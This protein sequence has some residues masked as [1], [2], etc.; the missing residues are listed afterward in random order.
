MADLI[1]SEKIE[2]D[3]IENALRPRYFSELIGRR[4]EKQ[5]LQILI[6]AAKNRSESLDHILFHGPPGLGKTSLAHIVANEVGVPLK[7]TSGPIM[8]RVGDLAAMLTTIE[9]NG[10]LFIDEIHRLNRT[11]EE[12]LYSAME[13]FFIDIA[14]GKGTTANTLHYN[15]P[16]FTIIGATTRIGLISS[17]LRD[18]FGVIYRLDYY[19]VED[20]FEIVKHSAV[21]LGVEIDDEAAQEIAL[22]SRGTARIANRL[23]KRTRDYAQVKEEGKINKKN[24]LKALSLNEVD[25][26]GLDEI[27]R[28]I[29][30]TII[31]NYN[32]GP[33]GVSTISVA[34]SEGIDTVEEV[35]EPF[36]I[37][38]G[39]LERTPKG[40][41]AT[42]KAYE[43][44]G[45]DYPEKGSEKTMFD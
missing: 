32:G 24:A 44:L 9:E 22:R 42:K 30:R 28:K 36:L 17:P 16:H 25:E 38:A 12:T 2:E 10:I 21:T 26:F 31:N 18:R 7:S 34:I 37:Q 8:T 14:M 5:S 4:A 3:I 11:V 6:D 40:R 35:Y 19:S 15:L 39:F 20:L 13:D 33:V 43:H 41:M 29:L 23:L 45:I 27:D 1:K